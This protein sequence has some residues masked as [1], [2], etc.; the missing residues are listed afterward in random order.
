MEETLSVKEKFVRDWGE[1]LAQK[2]EEAANSH[3][4]GVNDQKIGDPFKWALL[5][6]IGYQCLEVE[7][8]RESHGIPPLDWEKMKI[9]IRDNAELGSYSGDFD[10]LSLWAGAYHFYVSKPDGVT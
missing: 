9:W 5:I 1:D 10:Y 3:R 8:Y 4:N 6:C 7:R 2:V